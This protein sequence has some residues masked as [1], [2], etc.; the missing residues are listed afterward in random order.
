MIEQFAK[1]IQ[2]VN[3]CKVGPSSSSL[4]IVAQPSDVPVTAAPSDVMF[5]A[6]K[7]EAPTSSAAF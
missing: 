4:A 1:S 2:P 7:R 5:N 6:V 3:A